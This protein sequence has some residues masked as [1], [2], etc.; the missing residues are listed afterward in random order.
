MRVV[1]TSGRI[2]TVAGTGKAGPGIEDGEALAVTFNGPKHVWIERNDDVLI[3]DSENHV[4]RRL[5]VREQRVVRVAGTGR[6]GA[7]AP[8]PDPRAIALS[9]PHGIYVGP[10]GAIFVS[11]SDNG[12][13]LR[14][15]RL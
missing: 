10:D 6:R 15:P 14:L 4:I 12:R 1:D 7:G 5:V 2:R 11:D 9:R 13:I 8:G 3:A